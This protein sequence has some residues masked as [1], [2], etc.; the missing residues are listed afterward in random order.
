MTT[1]NIISYVCLQ[2][3]LTTDITQARQF[4]EFSGQ[5]TLTQTAMHTIGITPV[6][7]FEQVNMPAAQPPSLKPHPPSLGDRILD[8]VTYK[9]HDFE[10]RPPRARQRCCCPVAAVSI[11]TATYKHQQL[12]H[13]RPSSRSVLGVC[14][15]DRPH[16]ASKVRLQ[17]HQ[18]LTIMLRWQRTD[19]AQRDTKRQVTI[20]Y[21]EKEVWIR[22]LICHGA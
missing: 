5:I 21:K 22:R 9:A 13:T 7:Q 17:A 19:D 11:S 1:F 15:H 10:Q 18:A 6:S 14:L 16:Y 12:L 4:G 8:A 2:T 20:G 3:D